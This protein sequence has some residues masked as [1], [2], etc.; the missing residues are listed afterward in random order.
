MEMNGLT[1]G[2]DGGLDD[3]GRGFLFF[4]TSDTADPTG[5]WTACLLLPTTIT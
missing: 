4:A 5:F 2:A 1:C 3:F